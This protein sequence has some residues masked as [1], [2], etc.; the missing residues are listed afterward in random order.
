MYYAQYA[1]ARIASIIRAAGEQGFTASLENLSLLTAEK[2]EEVLKKVGAF[3]QIV[4]D[5]AKHRTLHRIANYIQDL[6]A[7]FHSFYNAE[8]VL[9]VD[10]KELTEA[11]LALITAVKTTLANALRLIGVSAPEKM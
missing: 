11:R 1:H 5:A 2:E 3:P 9:N 8:K 6:A 7:A 4:A 10:N